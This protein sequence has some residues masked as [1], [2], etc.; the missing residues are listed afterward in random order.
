MYPLLLS[1]YMKSEVSQMSF[2]PVALSSSGENEHSPTHR[3][4]PSAWLG[5]RATMSREGSLT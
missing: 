3:A 2:E 5:W 1:N 4:P